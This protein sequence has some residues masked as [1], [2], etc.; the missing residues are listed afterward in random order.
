MVKVRTVHLLLLLV[1]KLITSI[2]LSSLAT[3]L[4]IALSILEALSAYITLLAWFFFVVD[5]RQPFWFH[6]R[7]C[8]GLIPLFDTCISANPLI[9][10]SVARLSDMEINLVM[11]QLDT[12]IRCGSVL[13]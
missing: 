7:P 3:W 12:L 11:Q 9:R 1:V 6:V 4:D 13:F 2:S 10:R 8:A 5:I